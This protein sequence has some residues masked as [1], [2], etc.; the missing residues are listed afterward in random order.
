MTQHL[1]T[2]R[3]DIVNLGSLRADRVICAYENQSLATDSSYA[4]SRLLAHVMESLAAA[5]KLTDFIALSPNGSTIAG[6]DN[7]SMDLNAFS[8]IGSRVMNS[9]MVRSIRPHA[10]IESSLPYQRATTAFASL[11]SRVDERTIV[12]AATMTVVLAARKRFPQAKIAY[13]VQGMPRLGQESLASR[14]VNSADIVIAPSNALYRDL[15][16]LICRDR[17]APPV[18]VLHNSIDR[19]NFTSISDDDKAN[20]R[21]EWQLKPTDYVIAHV[22]RAPEKGIQ[23]IESALTLSRNLHQDIVLVSAGGQSPGRRRISEHAEV[24]ETGRVTPNQLNRIYQVADLGVV[25]SVWW[26]NCPL[27]LI[28][29]MSIGLCTIGSRTGGIPELIEH[30]LNGM[31]VDAPNDVV[32]WAKMIDSLIADPDACKRMGTAARQSVAENLCEQRYLKQWEFV[33]N[34]LIAV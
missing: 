21:S 12:F 17:F 20:T 8:R 22:G 23:V 26:E 16:Q 7:R 24:L 11:G 6:V 9:R 33:L 30:G 15:F 2:K 31:I 3:S 4:V 28:E 19:S 1:Q 14:A 34:S 18:W 29:M 27:A 13:W 5:N 32:E 25:P 10:P